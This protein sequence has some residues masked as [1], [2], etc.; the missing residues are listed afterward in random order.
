MNASRL[1][2]NANV[3]ARLDYKRAKLAKKAEITEETQIKR[4]RELSQKA[5]QSGQ[6][7]AAVSAEDKI[8]TI[9]GLYAKDNLQK[10]LTLADILAIASGRKAVEGREKPLLGKG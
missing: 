3:K 7:S 6:I 5:E 2:T 9:C 8:A 1:L 4:F 10:N